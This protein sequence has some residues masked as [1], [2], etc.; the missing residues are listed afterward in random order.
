MDIKFEPRIIKEMFVEFSQKEIVKT[1]ISEMYNNNIKKIPRYVDFNSF[2]NIASKDLFLT[3]L[4]GDN[5][6]KYSFIRLECGFIQWYYLHL[7]SGRNGKIDGGIV[8]SNIP[9]EI[10]HFVLECNTIYTKTKFDS[11]VLLFAKSTNISDKTYNEVMSKWKKLSTDKK[12][13]YD[14]LYKYSEYAF[15]TYTYRY[16]KYK[17]LRNSQDNIKNFNYRDAYGGISCY[18]FS[19]L[20]GNNYEE[21]KILFVKEYE[22]TIIE[23]CNDYICTDLIRIIIQFL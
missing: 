7:T 13:V 5:Y 2:Y 22:N 15:N 3:L 11:P 10:L 12:L 21:E 18:D 20:F 17:Y 6:T 8:M 4:H 14:E 1:F 23:L 16:F 19:Y 9:E